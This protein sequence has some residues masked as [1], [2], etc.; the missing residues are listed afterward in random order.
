MKV[1]FLTLSY[2]PTATL[3]DSMKRIASFGYDG[4]DLWAYSP[5]L[6]PDHYS[7]K[8][9]EDVKKMAENLKIEI[10]GISLPG[11]QTPHLNP[12]HPNEKVRKDA[13][14]YLKDCVEL[15]LD[16]GAPFMP[17]VTGRLISGTTRK[18]ARIWYKDAIKETL[19]AIGDRNLELGIHPLPPYESDV[20]SNID[21]CLELREEIGS[22]RVKVIFECACANQIDPNLSDSIRKIGKH[23]GTVH[24]SDNDGTGGVHA[25]HHGL[26]GTGTIDW[27][28]IFRTLKEI[29]YNGDLAMQIFPGSL[30][31]VDGWAIRSLEFIRKFL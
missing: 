19:D 25:P 4:V 14:K 17:L 6:H 29:N 16:V 26:P 3:E 15:A 31:D 8:E 5:H 18:Q 20:V 9:R 7:K 11:P 12:S 1:T 30:Y 24:V 21:D 2:L 10:T 23:L 13:R 27:E 28:S 22:E